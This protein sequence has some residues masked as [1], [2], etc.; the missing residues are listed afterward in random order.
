[1]LTA[2][3][4][5]AEPAHT[6]LILVDV[7]NAFCAEGGAMHRGIAIM[8][9]TICVKTLMFPLA[10]KSYKSMN[11]MKRLQPEMKRLQEKHAADRA[12]DFV[13]GLNLAS[14]LAFLA[15]RGD[16]AWVE[17]YAGIDINPAALTLPAV[18]LDA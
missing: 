9:L 11:K 17:V 3:P 14:G 8:I 16:E 2:L 15:V 10:N 13:D 4:Q 5:K 1:M 18:P 12:R 6:A 7:L